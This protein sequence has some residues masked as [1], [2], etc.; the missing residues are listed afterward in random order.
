[1]YDA[2]YGNMYRETLWELNMEYMP[3]YLADEGDGG[4]VEKEP[5]EA[6]LVYGTNI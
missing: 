4:G 1:M 2:I 5:S 6:I 3:V